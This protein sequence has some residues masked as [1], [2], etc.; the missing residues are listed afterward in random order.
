M[1]D[2]IWLYL[3]SNGNIA[4]CVL[5]IFGVL[6]FFAGLI[7]QYWLAIVAGLYGVGVLGF[8]RTREWDLKEGTRLQ[9]E[10][11]REVLDSMVHKVKPKLGKELAELLQNLRDNLD[12]VIA[13][14]SQRETS[15]FLSHF[16]EK[17]VMDYLPTSIE[18]YL[19]LPP[20]Y[21]RMH[22][23]KDGFTSQDLLRKQLD[24]LNGET[25]KVI[26]DLHR[27]DIQS[28]QAHTRFLEEKYKDYDLLR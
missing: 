5:G 2:R 9:G 15:A 28:I 1:S 4:G 20:A 12:H 24:L 10:Q 23:I 16:V 22:V 8:P 21:R 18:R 7:D 17:T 3:Y 19:N 26:D 25:L 27:D 13:Q 6:A 14:M 11:L